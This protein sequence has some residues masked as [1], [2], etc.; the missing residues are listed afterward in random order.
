MYPCL[1]SPVLEPPGRS[2]KPTVLPPLNQVESKVFY[3]DLK[4]NNVRPIAWLGVVL[5]HL[6]TCCLCHWMHVRTLAVTPALA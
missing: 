3:V 2:A 6:V 5:L 4:S 1:A